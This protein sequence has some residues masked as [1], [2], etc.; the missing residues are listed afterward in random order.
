M[1]QSIE[2]KKILIFQRLEPANTWHF[3]L[4]NDT[5]LIIKVVKYFFHSNT[6][7][8]TYTQPAHRTPRSKFKIY[9][10][11]QPTIEREQI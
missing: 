11:K 5:Q 2:K 8:R 7:V 3:S 9:K 10:V 4:S 1:M 6:A